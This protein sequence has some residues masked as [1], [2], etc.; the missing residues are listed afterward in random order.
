MGATEEEHQPSRP[1]TFLPNV[2][3][4]QQ[5]L[6]TLFAKHFIDEFKQGETRASS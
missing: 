6:T 3:A 5:L 1:Y 2:T 4:K